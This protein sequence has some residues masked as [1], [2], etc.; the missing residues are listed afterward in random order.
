MWNKFKNSIKKILV[1]E[2][3]DNNPVVVSELSLEVKELIRDLT[4]I[5]HLTG[6]T[7][8]IRVES[9]RM[10]RFN[11]Y[12]SNLRDLVL[13]NSSTNKTSPFLISAGDFFSGC[14]SEFRKYIRLLIK[15]LESGRFS[16]N[17]RHD[18][19]ELVEF[20]KY[21]SDGE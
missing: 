20:F 14:E 11:M 21:H 6:I 4:K 19:K 7:D 5:Q 15:K 17:A 3:W 18:I 8:F 10:Y 1:T 12:T 9:V 16:L 2:P 13:T